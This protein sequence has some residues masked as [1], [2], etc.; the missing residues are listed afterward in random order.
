[1]RGKL[2]TQMGVS[3]LKFDEFRSRN[4]FLS[5]LSD[6]LPLSRIYHQMMKP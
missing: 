2:P 3:G 4:G 5:L 6:S 1:L